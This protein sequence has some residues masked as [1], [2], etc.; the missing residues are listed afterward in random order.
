M[1]VKPRFVRF[2]KAILALTTAKNR[3]ND[4]K[5]GFGVQGKMPLVIPKVVRKFNSPMSSEISFVKF[6]VDNSSLCK[7]SLHAMINFLPAV[8]IVSWKQ[9]GNLL[10]CLTIEMKASKHC[11]GFVPF[12][13]N[14]FFSGA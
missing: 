13:P 11:F 5:A 1:F 9:A 7:I 3:T 12:I 14:A 8:F 10:C 6:E 4:T 2:V